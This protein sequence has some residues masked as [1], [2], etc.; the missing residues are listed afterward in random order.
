MALHEAHLTSIPCP[1][2][3]RMVQLIRR[4]TSTGRKA[5]TGQVI[6]VQQIEYRAADDQ[7]EVF[8]ERQLGI[9]EP[10]VVVVAC[11]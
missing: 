8:N 10:I 7:H 2:C 11:K 6:D 9:E 4:V 1:E 3:G 5:L